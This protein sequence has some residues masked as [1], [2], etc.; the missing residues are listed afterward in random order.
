MGLP[1]RPRLGLR[2]QLNT[3]FSGE[4]IAGGERFN[5]DTSCEGGELLLPDECVGARSPLP[6]DPAP[7]GDPPVGA[8]MAPLPP[9][10]PLPLP[11]C[12]WLLLPP[13]A[14]PLPPLPPLDGGCWIGGGTIGPRPPIP[15]SAPSKP[16]N[17]IDYEFEVSNTIKT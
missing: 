7:D 16:K 11:I 12:V 8:P 9:V 3:G 13:T 14:K 2:G 15:P 17:K 10:V 5:G 4:P 1:S 6:P